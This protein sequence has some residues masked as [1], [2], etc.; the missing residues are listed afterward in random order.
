MTPFL[1]YLLK[2]NIVLLLLYG[3]YYLCLRRDTFYGYTRWYLLATL[4]AIVTLPMIDLSGWFVGSQGIEASQYIP[5]ANV[6]YQYIFTHPQTESAIEPI[7]T[8]VIPWGL[9]LWWG[10]LTV[11]IFFAG[12][13]IFQFI[14]LIRLRRRYPAQHH[15]SQAIVS[16]D[17][18]LQPF[19]FFG[20]I[21][22]NPALYTAEELNEI[23]AHEQVHCQQVHTIDI[24]LSEALVCLC[25]FNPAAWL[26]RNDLKQNLEYYTDRMTLRA[27]FN[28]KHYQYSLLRASGSAYQIVNHFHFNH[29]KKRIMMMNKKESPRILAAKYLLAVPALVAALMVVQIS[30]LQAGENDITKVMDERPAP[31]SITLSTTDSSSMVIE[32][33][34]SNTPVKLIATK[35]DDQ[36]IGTAMGATVIGNFIPDS[37]T[38]EKGTTPKL[39]FRGISDGE[40]PLFILNGKEL[41]QDEI[42]KID[43]RNIETVSVMKGKKA[44]EIF[45]EKAINGVVM[46][47]LKTGTQLNKPQQP[48]KLETIPDYR[49]RQGIS[50]T[51]SGDNDLTEYN[52]TVKIA[53]Q[54]FELILTTSTEPGTKGANSI[55]T[56]TTKLFASSSPKPNTKN[57]I[58]LIS[59]EEEGGTVTGIVT[60]VYYVEEDM[61]K[62]HI[63]DDIQIDITNLSNE[64]SE[65]ERISNGNYGTTTMTTRNKNHTSF[66]Q[67]NLPVSTDIKIL[68]IVDGKE[69]AST[70]N[71]PVERIQSITVLKGQSATSLYGEKAKNGVVVV[72]TKT[73]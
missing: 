21:F 16:I 61:P 6:V 72:T 15:G 19:S 8:K 53:P 67:K 3:F 38:H 65:I 73:E 9:I 56:K 50:L 70:E 63:T 18:N 55:K 51:E 25:W 68:Y 27:G 2:A 23:V 66:G 49:T 30:G 43:S 28:R 31:Y 32:M 5:N 36:M 33:G 59:M 46:I 39:V 7:A 60:P 12:K 1:S 40:S 20:H 24:L 4:M 10:W 22:L 17:R 52:R 57:K 48:V 45:G 35:G 44:I 14:S 42:N 47:T 13:R 26:L 37:S 11:V 34:E 64:L 62:D 54:P 58:S 69:I 29:L 71:L 41:S